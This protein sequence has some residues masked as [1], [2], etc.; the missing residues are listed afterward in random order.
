ML[1]PVAGCGEAWL[2]QTASLGGGTA[3]NRGDIGVVVLNN[4]PYRA[5]MTLGSYDQASQS[6]S[7]D[8][9]QFTLDGATQLDPDSSGGFLSFSCGRVFSLGGP[10]LLAAL[11]ASDSSDLSPDAMIEGIEFFSVDAANPDAQPVGQGKAAPYEVLL[12]VDFPC[13]SLLIFKLEVDEGG[14]DPF[15]VDYELLPSSSTR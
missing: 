10:R 1:F 4:T 6:F 15:R 14:P 13:N 7:P 5:V 8:A 2:N 12:G 9:K 3:G 11:S